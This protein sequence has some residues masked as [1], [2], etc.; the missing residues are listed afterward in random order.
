MELVVGRQLAGAVLPADPRTR[1]GA[2]AWGPAALQRDLELRLGVA[3]VEVSVSTRLPAWLER[4]ESLADDTAFYARSFAIDPLGTAIRLIEWRDRLFEAGWS[5]HTIPNGGPRLDALARLE[6]HREEQPHRLAAIERALSE[7]RYR[8]YDSVALIE[9]L[10]LWPGRW[11]SIFGQLASRGTRLAAHNFHFP[12]A[13]SDSD[14]GLLQRSLRGEAVTPVVRGDGSLLVLRGDTLADLAELTAVLVGSDPCSVVVRCKEGESLDQALR[15]H[16]VPAQG[17]AGESVWRPAMQLL[18]LALELAF[19]PRD[20]FRVLELL[21]LPGSPVRGLLGARLARAVARQ[22]GIGGKEW[23]LRKAEASSHL[24]AEYARREGEGRADAFVAERLQRVADWLEA[25]GAPVSGITREALLAVV[26]RVRLWHQTRIRA[27]EVETFAAAYAQ[28]VA[29]AEAARNDPRSSF[30]QEEVR[31]LFDRYARVEQGYTLSRE[32]AGRVAHVAHPSSLLGSRDRIVLWSF[33]GGIERRPQRAPWNDEERAALAAAGVA[34]V[35]EAATLASEAEAWRRAIL[36]A[37]QSVVFVVP[38]SIKGTATI[39]HPLWDEVRARLQL[40][41]RGEG[42]LT[43]EAR[44]VRRRGMPGVAVRSIAPLSLPEPRTA[45]HVPTALMHVAASDRKVSVTALERI[46]TC[47][48]AWLLEQRGGLHAGAVSKVATGT[49]L[50]GRLTHRLVEELHREGSFALAEDAFL[51]Q[52][53]EHFEALLRTEGATLLLPGASIEKLQLSRQVVAAVRA[54][55]RYLVEAGFSIAA[56]EEEI[57]T[58]SAIGPLHGRLDLRLVDRDGGAV[59]LDLKWGGTSFREA[60]ARGRAVQL[61]AYSRAVG[62]HP[63][64]GYFACSTGTVL[65]TDARLKPTET[66][67]GPSLE[68]TWRRVESTARLVLDA[69]ARGVIHVPAAKEQLRLLDLLEVSPSAQDAH[70]DGA[71]DAACG[72]CLFDA[73]CGRKWRTVL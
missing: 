6:A 4:I 19:D 27:G 61:A 1:L 42:S 49:L 11:R 26:E 65:T 18:A 48:L 12:L 22:P 53:G 5:G 40:D 34:L 8:I 41:E 16:G 9:P 36:A 64:A 15:V 66:I 43:R 23:L 57:S 56:V 52:A 73:I 62:G 25:P 2:P 7:T 30:T 10:D 35:E 24:H 44:S 28:T 63:P 17:H 29:F 38:R 70:F 13:P 14:L 46:V 37:R 55:H 21:T 50:S 68:E 47:P 60:L 59:V 31:Q 51:A 33:V 71:P 58:P 67:D 32:E 20:P 69:Q 54:L 45:W 39:P 3:P 72:H